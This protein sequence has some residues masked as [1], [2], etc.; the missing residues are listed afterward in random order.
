MR[1]I[2]ASLLALFASAAQAHPGEHHGNLLTSL[3]HLLTAPDHLAM[4]A[5][6]V[7]IGVALALRGRWQNSRKK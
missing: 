6:A 4:I 2:T 7:V 1:A 5:V 3:W